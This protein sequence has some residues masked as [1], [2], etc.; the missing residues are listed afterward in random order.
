MKQGG[1]GNYRLIGFG[2][3]EFIKT[4]NP[5]SLAEPRFGLGGHFGNS[6]SRVDIEALCDHMGRVDASTATEF[7]NARAGCQSFKKSC[8][9]RVNLVGAMTNICIR[10]RRIK[11]ERLRVAH[12]HR[13]GT[14]TSPE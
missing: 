12:F 2:R 1:I 5:H 7:E 13:V 8:N 10:L 14:G 3:I 4:H 6:I 9:C 11:I